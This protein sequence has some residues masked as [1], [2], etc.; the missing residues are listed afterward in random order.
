MPK[1]ITTIDETA[2]GAMHESMQA[3][4]IKQDDD[5]YVLDGVDDK[6]FAAKL[7]EFRTNNRTLTKKGTDAATQLA[8]MQ[9]TLDGLGDLSK[10]DAEGVATLQAAQAKMN[11]LEDAGLLK[12]GKIDELLA[13]RT[14][15]M[16]NDFTAKMNALTTERDG[17]TGTLET[18][19]TELGNLKIDTS[20]QTSIGKVGVPKQGALEN[21]LLLAHRDWAIADD[22]KMAGKELYDTDGNPHTMDTYAASLVKSHAYLFEPGGGGGAGGTNKGGGGGTS[23]TITNDPTA[24][25]A[26]LEDIA[27]GKKV[28]HHS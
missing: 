13:K 26:N 24:I 14:E 1:L 11:E 22:G 28:V 10:L 8:A 17:A 27:S 19:R 15:T 20:L 18:M 25:G 9:A 4:Y 7:T 23:G 16:R 5:S 2:H 21:L 3:L 12:D 6:D